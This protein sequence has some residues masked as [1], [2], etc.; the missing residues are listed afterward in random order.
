[1][2]GFAL[3]GPQVWQLVNFLRSLNIARTAQKAPGDAVR[4]AQLFETQGCTR[5][6]TVSGKGGFVGPDLSE[7]GG[8][9]S[10]AQLQRALL[11]PNS[12]VA[13]DYWSLRARTRGGET[14]TGIRLNED[15]DTFQMREGSGRLRTLWKAELA[16]YEI[17]RTSPMP[18]FEGRL[19]RTELDDLIAYLASLRPAP[20]GPGPTR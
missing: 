3:N 5:C 9:R 20:Q 17:I 15:T 19:Q 1:M 12:D 14:V 2:T 6:H 16:E 11:D 7:I 4:G 8:R 13:S 18:P 10:L